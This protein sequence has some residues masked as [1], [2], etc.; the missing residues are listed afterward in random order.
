MQI[1]KETG[2]QGMKDLDDIIPLLHRLRRSTFFTHDLGFFDYAL[3]HEG[4]TLICLDVE[5]KETAAYIRRC[6]RHPEFRSE[7]Q[8]MG[9]VILA[10]QR[11]L[12]FW[13]IGKSRLQRLSWP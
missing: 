2:R 9:K 7:K 10:R 4:Y 13:E 5:A 12:S 11:N 3:C 1:G 8:R 6:L